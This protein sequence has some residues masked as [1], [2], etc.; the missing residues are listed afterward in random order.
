MKNRF[1]V[2]VVWALL[3]VSLIGF[4]AYADTVV[5]S[6]EEIPAFGTAYNQDGSIR[7]SGENHVCLD[8]YEKDG[9]TYWPEECFELHSVP[10][11]EG[12]K[13][14]LVSGGYATIESIKEY[15]DVADWAVEAGIFNADGSP[16]P[17]YDDYK[18]DLGG[19]PYS[20][21]EYLIGY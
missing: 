10:V 7:F 2:L 6:P 19:I 4:T 15:T 1:T 11:K 12:D 13:L 18:D 21:V 16:G 9:V 5:A 20:T 3:I 8:S 14:V 17:N